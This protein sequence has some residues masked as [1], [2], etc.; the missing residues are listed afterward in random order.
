MTKL[1]SSDLT[2]VKDCMVLYTRRH[3]L[4][5]KQHDCGDTKWASCLKGNIGAAWEPTFTRWVW[6]KKAKETRNTHLR[7]LFE[8]TEEPRLDS[9][10]DG[11]ML[12]S[13]LDLE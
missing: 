5:G 10:G 13:C 6:L 11:L 4:A 7:S 9:L 12:L 2:L 1:G 3:A 8:I